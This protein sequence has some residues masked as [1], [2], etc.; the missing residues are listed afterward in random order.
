MMMIVMLALVPAVTVSGV[1][2]SP[3]QNVESQNVTEVSVNAT[4]TVS[5]SKQR[6]QYRLA[7]VSW[8]N[9]I[10][11]LRMSAIF[12][13]LRN[14]YYPSLVSIA[15]AA[16]SGSSSVSF[17]RDSMTIQDAWWDLDESM[18]ME[19]HRDSVQIKDVYFTNY[20]NETNPK[21]EITKNS[22]VFC[23]HLSDGEG[24]FD[25]YQEYRAW[26]VEDVIERDGMYCFDIAAIARDS[27]QLLKD[28]PRLPVLS[29][30]EI[31]EMAREIHMV[32][33]NGIAYENNGTYF[34]VR[35]PINRFNFF[36]QL[37]II[38][39]WACSESFGYGSDLESEINSWKMPSF[40]DNGI[41]D[42]E[43][44][45]AIEVSISKRGLEVAV[46]LHQIK[47]AQEVLDLSLIHISEPTRPY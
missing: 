19:L 34:N 2:T 17:A 29:R 4:P 28:M 43:R 32:D 6:R 30:L 42:R 12:K 44:C 35:L 41:D 33:G 1:S 47:I 11:D 13:W 45:G 26:C 14:E 27:K 8:K 20:V 18:D 21:I 9:R 40:E 31:L 7:Y 23:Y 25:T 16:S 39:D 36:K 46:A 5:N 22:R 38:S 3:V 15:D 10:A 37:D 24:M